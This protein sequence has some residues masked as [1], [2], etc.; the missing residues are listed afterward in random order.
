VEEGVRD[1]VWLIIFL[2]RSLVSAEV[3]GEPSEL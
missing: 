3:F 1:I 2:D